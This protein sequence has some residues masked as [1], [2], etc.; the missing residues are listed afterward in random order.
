[1]CFK[2]V[3]WRPLPTRNY[4]VDMFLHFLCQGLQRYKRRVRRRVNKMK[5]GLLD[6]CSVKILTESSGDEDE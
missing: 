3:P 6:A 5:A 4:H 1:M 2:F